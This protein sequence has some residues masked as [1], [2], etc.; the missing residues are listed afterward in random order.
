[1]DPPAAPWQPVPARRPPLGG[2]R[3]LSLLG[4]LLL[5]GLLCHRWWEWLHQ[6]PDGKRIGVR[7]DGGRITKVCVH[8][9]ITYRETPRAPAH[10]A[11]P[12]RRPG[13]VREGS[14]CAPGLR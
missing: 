4:R 7:N 6:T 3:L 1:M 10:A 5:G 2:L 13:Y 8:P 14:G 9:S 11:L 12:R